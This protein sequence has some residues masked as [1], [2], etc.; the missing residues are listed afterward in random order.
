L[1]KPEYGED[2]R[3]IIPLSR[4]SPV[5]SRAKLPF[6]ERLTRTRKLANGTVL[7]DYAEPPLASEYSAS[8]MDDDE[9]EALIAEVLA[10][11][12]TEQPE[13]TR[14][15]FG[16]WERNNLRDLIAAEKAAKAVSEPPQGSPGADPWE[17]LNDAR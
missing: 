13:E 10:E 9:Y 6:E 1:A 4:S 5:D 7:T 14:R 17:R 11:A 15:L 16:P 8:R 3:E 12:D 2:G